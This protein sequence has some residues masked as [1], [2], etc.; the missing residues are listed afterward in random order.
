MTKVPITSPPTQEIILLQV[1]SSMESTSLPV[2]SCPK[3]ASDLSFFWTSPEELLNISEGKEMLESP[4]KLKEPEK[5]AKSWFKFVFLCYYFFC[6]LP[7]QNSSPLTRDSRPLNQSLKS[8][9]VLKDSRPL[10]QMIKSQ[11]K[12]HL[13]QNFGVQ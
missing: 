2:S 9:E 4:E 3:I 11:I 12:S 1:V 6:F 8:S 13:V 5:P 10:K 7:N